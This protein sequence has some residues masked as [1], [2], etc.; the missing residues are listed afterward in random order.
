MP[1]PGA[2]PGAFF[3]HFNFR[4]QLSQ[5][6]RVQKCRIVKILQI[7]FSQSDWPIQS[8]LGVVAQLVERTLRMREAWSSTLHCSKY[9][10]FPVRRFISL[11]RENSPA[12]SCF[13]LIFAYRPHAVLIPHHYHHSRAR[14]S[15]LSLSSCPLI[16]IL[17]SLHSHP[18]CLDMATP[19]GRIVY[20]FLM[21]IYVD[22]P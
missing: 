1:G 4:T 8:G 14:G 11:R 20:P 19:S 10:L 12:L 15:S 9:L 18:T 22:G 2:Q 6:R 21:D 16:T 13:L 3:R 5:I 17:R 7:G